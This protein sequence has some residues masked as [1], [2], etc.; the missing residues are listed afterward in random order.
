MLLS[1]PTALKKRAGATEKA[2]YLSGKQSR[3]TIAAR[4][5]WFGLDNVN[6]HTGA[7]R[8]IA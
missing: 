1:L 4:Q 5:K 3:A 7:V 2:R 8:T 6:P